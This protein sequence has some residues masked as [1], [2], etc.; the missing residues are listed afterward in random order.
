MVRLN[1]ERRGNGEKNRAADEDVVY[2]MSALLVLD[3]ASW[4]AR[5]VHNW[6][7]AK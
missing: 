6:K 2:H 3:H 7:A 4:K 5:G 1:T